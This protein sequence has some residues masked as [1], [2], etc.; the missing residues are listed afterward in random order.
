MRAPPMLVTV[1]NERGIFNRVVSISDIAVTDIAYHGA[2][3]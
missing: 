1:G 3:H 2:N